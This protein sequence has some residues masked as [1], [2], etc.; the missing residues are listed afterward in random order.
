[1]TFQQKNNTVSLASFSL[2]LIFFLLRIAQLVRNQNFNEPTVVRLW[3]IVAVLAVVVTV[4]GIM[5]T[6]GIPAAV[7]FARTGDPEPEIDDLVDERDQRIDLEGFKL[8]YRITSIGT[9]V[10][11]LTFALG[12]PPLVMF[13]L[14][15]FFGLAGQIAGDVLRLRRYQQE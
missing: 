5:L 11:M 3:I 8:T 6:H 15:I 1:M 7:K 13:S 12:Q 4:V 2:L 10:A 9:F 14:L